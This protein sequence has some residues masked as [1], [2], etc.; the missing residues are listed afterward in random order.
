MPLGSFLGI[1]DTSSDGM[2][3]PGE[4]CRGMNAE[5]QR[6]SPLWKMLSNHTKSGINTACV[7]DPSV[8]QFHLVTDCRLHSSFPRILYIITYCALARLNTSLHLDCDGCSNERGRV[9]GI[10]YSVYERGRQNMSH[11]TGCGNLSSCHK[12]LVLLYT[13]SICSFPTCFY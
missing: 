9:N 6:M 12:G 3:L 13:S 7:S 5:R 1:I 4:V 11:L 10:F 8:K 2:C